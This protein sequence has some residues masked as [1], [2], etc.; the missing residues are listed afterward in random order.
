MTLWSCARAVAKASESDRAIVV[1]ARAAHCARV[2]SWS[3][4]G[5]PGHSNAPIRLD[6]SHTSRSGTTEVERRWGLLFRGELRMGDRARHRP[7]SMS[8]ECW[9]GCYVSGTKRRGTPW[10]APSGASSSAP[11]SSFR[12]WVTRGR[13]GTTSAIGDECVVGSSSPHRRT[14]RRPKVSTYVAS[15]PVMLGWVLSPRTV[16]VEVDLLVMDA[17]RARTRTASHRSASEYS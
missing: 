14:P 13:T 4:R 12:C 9:S 11:C 1:R 17:T 8:A 6:V 2:A 7:H 3:T 5:V 10:S 15:A 16:P